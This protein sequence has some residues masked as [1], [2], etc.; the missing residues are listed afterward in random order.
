[1]LSKSGRDIH[2]SVISV[3]V[4]DFGVGIKIRIR[5]IHAFHKTPAGCDMHAYIDIEKTTCVMQTGHIR[6]R[7]ESCIALQLC[8]WLW[9]SCT[10]KVGHTQ[11]DDKRRKKL[12]CYLFLVN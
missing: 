4:I 3:S 8:S 5:H 9:L 11:A 7:S 10:R 2:T 6:K 1:M 12:G